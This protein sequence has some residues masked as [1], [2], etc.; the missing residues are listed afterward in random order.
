VSALVDVQRQIVAL[1]FG[2]EPSAELLAGLGPGRWLDYRELVR[3]R[4]LRQIRAALPRTCALVPESALLRAFVQHLACEPPRTRFFRELVRAFADS[5]LPL[6]AAD[7]GLPS[8]CCD[9]LRYELALWELAD[10][11]DAP[12]PAY[13]D[14]DFVSIPVLAPALRLMT[15]SHAVHLPDDLAVGRHRLCLVRS[16]DG[17]FAQR[18]RTFS[19]NEPTYALL[20]RL[21]RGDDEP[22]SRTLRRMAEE[23]GAQLDG[24]YVDA[25]CTTLTQFIEL[26]IV[27]GSR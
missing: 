20:T 15:V 16:P 17:A 27:L 14:F 2:A 26:G 19:L 12:V 11:D 6:W 22:L 3:D 25:L 5:A 21:S 13:R 24:A 18:P 9:L 8:A 23:T 1:C 7:V 10:L 4:M